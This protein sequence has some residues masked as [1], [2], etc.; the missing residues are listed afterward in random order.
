MLAIRLFRHKFLNFAAP[1]III[2][3]L[4]NRCNLSCTYCGLPGLQDSKLDLTGESLENHLKNL[5]KSGVKII[6]ITGGEPMLHPNFE[7][8][9][10]TCFDNGVLVSLNSNGKNIS[11]R[12]NFLK[13]YIYQ[14]II[15]L[16]GEKEVHDGLRGVGSFDIAIKAIKDLKKNKIKT[17]STCVI[18]K[19][20]MINLKSLIDFFSKE[21]IKVLFQPI[22]K[23]TLTE[24]KHEL[25]LSQ[26]QVK[27]FFEVI[28]DEKKGGNKFIKNSRGGLSAWRKI[29]NQPNQ[30]IQCNAGKVFARISPNGDLN[31]CGRVL[32]DHISFD[33]I[34]KDN[35][36]SAFVGLQAAPACTSC[37]AWSAINLNDL[38]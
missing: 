35:L 7:A 37:D 1:T 13:K 4:T 31:R 11:S 22:F 32:N 24:E 9:V 12:I 27:Y 28:L 23:N 5:I 25:G 10:K 2:W 8:F 33:N 20:S 16:D 30:V 26:R 29:L 14:V 36:Q 18:T 38:I 34:T 21:K 19:K 15:S 3:S 17:S 6:S